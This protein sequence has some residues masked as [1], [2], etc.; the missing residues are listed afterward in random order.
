MDINVEYDE[1]EIVGVGVNDVSNDEGV[2]QWHS[3]T[4][5][6]RMY[7]L[8]QQLSV[9]VLIIDDCTWCGAVPHG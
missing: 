5:L 4:I 6:F 1:R 3:I 2:Q 8:E 9:G 7:N